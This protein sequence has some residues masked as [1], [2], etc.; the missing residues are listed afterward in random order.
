M[1]KWIENL[2]P[3]CLDC[4]KVKQKRSDIHEANLEKWTDTVPFPFHT[5]HNDQK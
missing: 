4:Q 3:D 2:I 5:V 1:Y